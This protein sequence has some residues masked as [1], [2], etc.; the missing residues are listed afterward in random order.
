MLCYNTYLSVVGDDD[1]GREKNAEDM[2]Q[3]VVANLKQSTE[4]TVR[5]TICAGEIVTVLC[6]QPLLPFM[7]TW[8]SGLFPLVARVCM[9]EKVAASGSSSRSS[10]GGLVQKVLDEGNQELSI[11]PSSLVAR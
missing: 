4:L 7:L 1:E 11:H 3:P 8:R 5:N 9:V 6:L 2:T 10:S